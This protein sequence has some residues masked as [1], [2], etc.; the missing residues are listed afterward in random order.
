M[1]QS[2]SVTELARRLADYVNRV[3]YRGESFILVRGRRQVAELRPM[4]AGR[5]LGDLPNLLSDLPRLSPEEAAGFGADIAA[6]RTQAGAAE[7]R[8]PWES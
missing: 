2:V 6:A 4:P 8:D 7:D 1:S 5:R 3:A